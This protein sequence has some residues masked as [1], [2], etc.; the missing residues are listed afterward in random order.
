M[1]AFVI[2]LNDAHEKRAKVK[3]ILDDVDLNYN[4]YDAVDGR[5]NLNKY[6]FNV[7]ENWFEPTYHFNMTEGEIGCAL[8]HYFIWKK[9]IDEGIG[10][11]LILEDDFVI[12]DEH[13]VNKINQIKIEYDFVYLGRKKMS[14]KNE[15][16]YDI[17]VKPEFSYWTI[18]YIITLEGAK[19]LYN[20]TYINNLIP[21][22]EYI[23]IMYNKHPCEILSKLYNNYNKL[24]CFAFDPPLIKPNCNAFADSLTFSSKPYNYVNKHITVLTVATHDNDA[25]QRYIK[26][27]N[28]Y[29]YNYEILGLG[30][31]WKGGNMELGPG[32]GQKVNLLKEYLNK[33]N[34]NRLIVF[35]DSYDVISNNHSSILYDIYKSNYDG[36]IVFSS[37]YY[38]WPNK[39]LSSQYPETSSKMKYLNSGLFIGYANDIKKILEKDIE[40]MA[41]DQLYYTNEMLD[42]D[43]V[44]LNYDCDMFLCMNGMVNEI[45]LEMREMCIKYNNNRPCF[46]HANGGH[47]IKRSL[48]S[49]CNYCFGGWNDIYT[50]KCLNRLDLN[51]LPNILICIYETLSINK[52][53]LEGVYNLDYPNEK[54]SLLIISNNADISLLN[55]RYGNISVIKQN[56]N[57]YCEIEK[58]MKF[59][60]SDKLLYIESS[61]I[62]KN[63]NCLLN[64]IKENR[65]YISPMIVKNNSLLSNFWGEL[66]DNGF[67]RRSF[68]YLDI[69]Q[70][71]YYGCWNV[72]YVWSCLLIDKNAF[73]TSM[74]YDNLDKGEGVDMAFCFNV[75]NNNDYLYVLNDQ[76][77]GELI[78]DVCLGDLN[79]EWEEKYLHP[80]FYMI[81][82]RLQD[83]KIDE[84]IDDVLKFNMFNKVFCNDLI[85]RCEEL[86]NWSEGNDT[87][88][89]DKRLGAKENVPT[90][91]IHLKQ[92]GLENLWK[93]I[94][95]KYISKI[96]YGYYAITTKDINITFV[97][98]YSMDGQ[99]ELKPHHDSSTYTTSICLNDEFEGGGCHF[100]KKDKSICN[101]D[102]GSITIHPGKVTHLH[103]GLPITK[104]KRYILVSF[105]N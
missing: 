82:D 45:T 29:G 47:N 79:E 66:D 32:G 15:E 16:R 97:V 7:Y 65:K 102:I 61:C 95:D 51:N 56:F 17:I 104:G 40:D 81:R 68:D 48:N 73:K 22:D 90:Q 38:C 75:R 49:M 71:K 55:N 57:S 93:G 100:I 64:L 42:R 21:V 91:D 14:N 60:N 74:F 1:E 58:Y 37:E 105:I 39:D 26:S 70:N 23:P 31:P 24:N 84:P 77:Y 20:N 50:Y 62:L 12:C 5:N 63:K 53:F 27:F 83:L 25:L 69:V 87:K 10:R 41:D 36:K 88:E 44:V 72:P 34:D 99:K 54:V 76:Q 46:V 85:K 89:F 103:R 9:I 18:G 67:Y 101:K 35:T 3:S 4:I 86:G 33:I 78:E 59:Y 52:R 6:N 11:V 19:K 28:Y 98:K 94:V 92:I 13:V 2:S 96:M 30:K 8:S 43:K 80:D